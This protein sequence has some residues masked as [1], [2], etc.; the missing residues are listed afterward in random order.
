MGKRIGKNTVEMENNPTI[1]S[2]AS[3]CGKKKPKGLL[4]INLI[5]LLK[6]PHSAKIHGKNQK[7]DYKLRQ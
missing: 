3:I 1:Y 6:I 5:K 2:F 4:E 7:A